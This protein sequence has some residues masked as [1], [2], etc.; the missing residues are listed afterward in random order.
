MLRLLDIEWD[1]K[2]KYGNYVEGNY[3]NLPS[4]VIIENPSQK[5]ID[6]AEK[7]QW[8]GRASEELIE[9]L[10]ERYGGFNVYDFSVEIN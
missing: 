1:T 6:A 4:T 8:T 5:L 7:M 9:Y 3:N 10:S 2:D